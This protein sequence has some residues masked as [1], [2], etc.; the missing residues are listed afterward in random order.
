MS[1]KFDDRIRGLANLV[2]LR[3]PAFAFTGAGCST[4]SGIPDFRSPGGVWSRYRMI[5]FQ[6]FLE[7]EQARREQW[8]L[9][10]DLYAGL[11]AARPNAAHRALARLHS[12]GLLEA[13]VTQ[14]IDGLHQAAG[15][16]PSA[17]IELHGNERGVICLSCGA[18]YDRDEIQRR[19]ED[20]LEIPLCDSCGG[21]LKTTTV[22]FGEPLPSDA[23][24]AAFSLAERARL[25]L[26]VGSSLAVY[27][28]ASVPE[29]AVRSGAAL[30]VINR[31]PTPL[32]H[33][34]DL[35]F[36]EPAGEVLEA[37]VHT[38]ESDA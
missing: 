1:E 8:A 7:S 16:P 14:N 5:T 22:W 15:M 12:L 24:E 28:A 37:L 34:A 3:K 30:A 11:S 38:L 18:R 6:E 26:V 27:P 31:D 33:A 25:C 32:D 20:G 35:I 17:V 36:R 10:R 21:L 19:L 2:R 9:H 4:E 13:V 29:L 23:L